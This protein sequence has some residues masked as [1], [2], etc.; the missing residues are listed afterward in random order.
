MCLPSGLQELWEGLGLEKRGNTKNTATQLFLRHRL[1][2]RKRWRGEMCSFSWEGYTIRKQSGV[3]QLANSGFRDELSLQLV[4][5]ITPYG[6]KGH[7]YFLSLAEFVYQDTEDRHGL[8]SRYCLSWGLGGSHF[9][10]I[11]ATSESASTEQPVSVFSGYLLWTS[12]AEV[13]EADMR[14]WKPLLVQH[15]TLP[16]PARG[17]TSLYSPVYWGSVTFLHWVT[18][19]GDVLGTPSRPGSLALQNCSGRHLERGGAFVLWIGLSPCL[20]IGECQTCDLWKVIT[21]GYC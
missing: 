13:P 2:I 17:S 9:L 12:G 20:L 14:Q 11:P 15:S 19:T 6:L 18:W 3:V 5:R 8:T 21:I 7:L 4:L 10:W 1:G 16:W